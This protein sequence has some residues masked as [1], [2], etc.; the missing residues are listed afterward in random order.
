MDKGEHLARLE[1][2]PPTSILLLHLYPSPSFL[3]SFLPSL[4]LSFPLR[5]ALT[6]LK[7]AAAFVRPS[8]RLTLF[9]T[10]ADVFSRSEEKKSPQKTSIFPPS[11]HFAI[12]A[13]P[14]QDGVKN[15]EYITLFPFSKIRVIAIKGALAI[16]VVLLSLAESTLDGLSYQCVVLCGR[17]KAR[18]SRLGAERCYW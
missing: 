6:T 5:V 4:F 17:Q 7:G 1:L 2:V 13:N 10:F 14:H 12:N 9:F 18:T 15:I 3:P 8:V 11:L 16:N